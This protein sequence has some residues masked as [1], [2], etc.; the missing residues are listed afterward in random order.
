MFLEFSSNRQRKE[1]IVNRRKFKHRPA[2]LKLWQEWSDVTNNRDR[3]QSECCNPRRF[4]DKG[5][6][7]NRC[8]QRA[9]KNYEE[10]PNGLYIKNKWDMPSVRPLNY[11]GWIVMNR[12]GQ[13]MGPHTHDDWLQYGYDSWEYFWDIH[14]ENSHVCDRTKY[15]KSVNWHPP[16]IDGHKGPIWANLYVRDPSDFTA[17]LLGDFNPI[18]MLMIHHLPSEIHKMLV[19]EDL[20]LGIDLNEC[21]GPIDRSMPKKFRSRGL[22]FTKT[23]QHAQHA[24]RYYNSPKPQESYDNERMEDMNLKNQYYRQRRLDKKNKLLYHHFLPDDVLTMNNL[25]RHYKHMPYMIINGKEQKPH[26]PNH[27]KT[28]HRHFN[29]IQAEIEQFVK[30][31]TVIMLKTNQKAHI[32]MAIMLVNALVKPR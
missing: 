28:M 8:R 25:H 9:R 16:V 24:K 12:F 19:Y 13:W 31:G 3:V 30:N 18:Q 10:H 23:V 5:L 11:K 4:K 17:G 20:H 29:L 14:Q 21:H 22:V 1:I 6:C 15:P 26:F 2:D 7:K 27:Q 32:Q